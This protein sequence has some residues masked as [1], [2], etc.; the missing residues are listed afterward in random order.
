MDDKSVQKS[1]K[2]CENSTTTSLKRK[3]KDR[4]RDANGK[5]SLDSHPVPEDITSSDDNKHSVRQLIQTE[6]TRSEPKKTLNGNK[7]MITTKERHKKQNKTESDESEDNSDHNWEQTLSDEEMDDKNGKKKRKY[8]K[9]SEK[10]GENLKTT[11]TTLKKKY[12]EKRF[13]SADG[14]RFRPKPFI[15]EY[16]GCEKRVVDYEQL[17][18]HIRVRHTMER[19]FGCDVCHKTYPIERYLRIHQKMHTEDNR[20]FRCSWV[21]CD[22]A[23]RTKQ[24]LRDHFRTHEQL[25]QYACDE[26]DQRFN[27]SRN[28]QAHKNGRHSTAR[29]YTCDWPACE[30]TYKDTTML[31]RHKETHLGVRQYVCDREGCGKGFVTNH[32][33]YQHKRQ[34]LRP[35]ACSWPACEHRFG[36]NDKLVDHMNSHQGLRVVECPVEGCDKT[37]TSKPCARQ[38]LRQVHKYKTTEEEI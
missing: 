27:T 4:T 36:S 8:V 35:F 30:A 28:L 3:Y 22:S 16:I 11:T 15:C 29:P 31:K 26:C 37:F 34:H 1:E 6:D 14:K 10:S 33:L 7:L 19:P 12:K 24:F 21:G 32:G 17:L 13:V 2:S 38:H 20:Q 9:K 25:R 23:F 18:A 5:P